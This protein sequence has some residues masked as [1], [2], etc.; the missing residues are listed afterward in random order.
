METVTLTGLEFMSLVYMDKDKKSEAT[1]FV[2]FHLRYNVF[3]DY[4][5]HLKYV[6]PLLKCFSF[7]TDD[8]Q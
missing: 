1:I 4:I 8:F 3:R 7:F 6:V 2:Y 5:F